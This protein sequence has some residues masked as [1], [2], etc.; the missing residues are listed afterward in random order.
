MMFQEYLESGSGKS[1]LLDIIITPAGGKP[2]NGIIKIDNN[3][4]NM[5]K[6]Y[7]YGKKLDISGK[8]SM[9]LLDDTILTNITLNIN[10]NIKIDKHTYLKY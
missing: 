5:K 8:A 7:S 1:T 2:T 6:I 10:N 9:I 3:L 4:M